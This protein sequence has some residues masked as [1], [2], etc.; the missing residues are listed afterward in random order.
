MRERGCE[1]EGERE[2]EGGRREEKTEWHVLFQSIAV[3]GGLLFHFLCSFVTV[4][5]H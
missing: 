1:S 3:E 4:C 2:R 5:S